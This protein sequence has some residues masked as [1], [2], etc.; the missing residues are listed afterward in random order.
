MGGAV[1]LG[2][3]TVAA[4]GP[5][6]EPEASYAVSSH[7]GEVLSYKL[8]KH[9]GRG[10]GPGHKEHVDD[11]AAEQDAPTACPSSTETSSEASDQPSEGETADPCPPPPPPTE[12]ETQPTPP[13]PTETETETETETQP[14]PSPST[15]TETPA[16]PPG[17]ASGTDQRPPPLVLPPGPGRP[18]PLV[19][20]VTGPVVMGASR[21]GPIQ[22]ASRS[23]SVLAAVAGPPGGGPI[24]QPSLALDTFL[25]ELPAVAADR[26]QATMAKAAPRML[27]SGGQVEDGR[28]PLWLVA[29]VSFLILLMVCAASLMDFN[30]LVRDYFYRRFN[31]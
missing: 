7:D 28:L 12:T 9:D 23:S 19:P 8:S 25:P 16:P 10:K 31:P 6:D 27:A 18:A 26:D 2:A 14:T 17:G 5:A 1:L 29:T 3:Q 22:R 24:Y 21:G 4:P 20:M 15:E 30:G 11:D 13:P